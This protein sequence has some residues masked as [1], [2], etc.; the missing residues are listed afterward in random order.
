MIFEATEVIARAKGLGTR[1]AGVPSSRYKCII[2][3]LFPQNKIIN[4]LWFIFTNNK[5]PIS[6]ALP[7]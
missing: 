5:D 7:G 2:G 6:E 1:E 3:Y 4:P